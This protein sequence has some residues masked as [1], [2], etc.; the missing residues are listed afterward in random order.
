MKFLA[1]IVLAQTMTLLGMSWTN[2][3]GKTLVLAYLATVPTNS[4]LTFAHQWCPDMATPWSD[5]TKPLTITKSTTNRLY[6]GADTSNGF[7]RVRIVP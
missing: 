6:A 4:T 3:P 5:I 1:I 2:W 7:F